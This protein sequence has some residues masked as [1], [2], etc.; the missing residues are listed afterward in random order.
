M[1]SA[2]ALQLL[3]LCMGL[4]KAVRFFSVCLSTWRITL[5]KHRHCGLYSCEVQIVS[6]MARNQFFGVTCSLM[7]GLIIDHNQFLE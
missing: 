3:P 7:T 5:M 6:I 4:D 2:P 1:Q